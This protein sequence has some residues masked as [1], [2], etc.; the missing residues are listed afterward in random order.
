[1]LVVRVTQI[2][3]WCLNPLINLNVVKEFVSGSLPNNQLLTVR[4]TLFLY[5]PNT[6]NELP[7][8]WIINSQF[9]RFSACC[10]GRTV[11]LHCIDSE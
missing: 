10:L 1:M 6:N 11:S 2:A 8:N 5:F 7:D 9:V 4:I 3:L